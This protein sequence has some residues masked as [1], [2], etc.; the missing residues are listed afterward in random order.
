M[1]W[2][3][4][5]GAVLATLWAQPALA[6][7]DQFELMLPARS[8]GMAGL[9][10]SFAAGPNALYLNPAALAATKQYVIGL[11]HN[12]GGV[13]Y[14]GANDFQ[15][16]S[17]IE[18]TDSTP[19]NMHLAMGAAYNY[20]WNEK[21]HSAHL[22]IAGAIA[23]QKVDILLGVGGHYANR[24][25][26]PQLKRSFNDK[27]WAMDVGLSLNV[28][29]KLMVGVAGYN[30]LS[31][32]RAK[33]GEGVPMGVGGGLSY[34]T[35]NWMFG[36][37]VTASFDA[38]TRYRATETEIIAARKEAK[39]AAKILLEE[40]DKLAAEAAAMPE[41][42]TKDHAVA[43]AED[44]QAAA[45]LAMDEAEATSAADLAV[46]RDM[47][48]FILGLQYC[49]KGVAFIR[50]GLRYDWHDQTIG[51][52]DNP[53]RYALGLSFVIKRFAIE[54]AWQQNIKDTSDFIFGINIEIYNPSDKLR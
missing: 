24:A 43:E 44:A 45:T 6:Q 51:G 48:S 50:G 52:T 15:N 8:V 18:W 3:T 22:A 37:D 17:S 7:F 26:I 54:V 28:G 14:D 47:V 32:L 36:F 53:W 20:N 1:K 33:D 29:N 30:L 13:K 4:I 11:A 21:V 5:V 16:V 9:G 39:A 46:Q 19:N 35:G 12:L 23:T 2:A 31:T 25:Y 34:W 40:A 49:I 38:L 27:F 41:G 42:A 10:R